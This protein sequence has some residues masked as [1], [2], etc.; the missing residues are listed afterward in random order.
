MGR[1]DN[2]LRVLRKLQNLGLC[3]GRKKCSFMMKSCIYLGHRLDGTG[4]HPTEEKIVAII[5]APIPKTVSELRSYL[6][7]VNYY[8]KFLGN[9]STI[10]APLYELLRK[11]V[12]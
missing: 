9:L 3:L 7:L 1:L 8:H 11:D 10:L 5:N 4:I 12:K 2:L 6:G